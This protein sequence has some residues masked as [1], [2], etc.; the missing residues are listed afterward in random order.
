MIFRELKKTF[1]RDENTPSGSKYTVILLLSKITLVRLFVN[2]YEF[3]PFM[4][5]SP[6]FQQML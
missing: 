1:K 4:E 3:R 5:A 6:K 2:A